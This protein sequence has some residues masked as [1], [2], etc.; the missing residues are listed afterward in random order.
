M[1]IEFKCDKCGKCCENLNLSHEYDDLNDGS[2]ICIYF[3]KDTRLCSIYDR[4][5][6]KCNVTKSYQK[7][8]DRLTYDEYLELNYSA[9]RKLKG[10]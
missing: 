1:G 3:D 6:D 5:P 8:K 9:C 7:M 4:R 10:E 2:G